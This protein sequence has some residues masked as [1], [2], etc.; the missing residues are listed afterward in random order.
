LPGSSNEKPLRRS[1]SRERKRRVE[2]QA[3]VY[4]T[5]EEKLAALRR[6]KLLAETAPKS[7]EEDHKVVEDSSLEVD[8]LN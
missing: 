4:E 6:R 2:P 3:F 1:P 7:N 5:E 8:W